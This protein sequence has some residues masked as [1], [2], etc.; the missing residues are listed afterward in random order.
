MNYL[1]L[2]IFLLGSFVMASEETLGIVRIKNTQPVKYNAVTGKIIP[3]SHNTILR[4]Q[5]IAYDEIK[6]GKVALISTQGDRYDAL[7]V[8]FDEADNKNVIPQ[9]F[10]QYLYK[11]KGFQINVT[12]DVLEFD[13]STYL[14][15]LKID[16]EDV[17]L[18]KNS[19]SKAVS[20]RAIV[21]PMKKNWVRNPRTP[22]LLVR[23]NCL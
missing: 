18:K 21:C 3:D 2:I 23:T 14:S 6:P 22:G 13:S 8:I 19:T 7:M 17:I 1:L 4:I 12:Q 16:A 11:N 9:K 10:G 15:K 20:L 5:D